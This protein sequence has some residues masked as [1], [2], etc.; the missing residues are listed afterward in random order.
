MRVSDEWATVFW[1]VFFG[2]FFFAQKCYLTRHHPR[3]YLEELV[4]KYAPFENVRSVA[5]VSCSTGRGISELKQ[6]IAELV[7][8]LGFFD[9]VRVRICCQPVALVV[10]V[11]CGSY[12]CVCNFANFMTDVMMGRIM[13][14]IS[15]YQLMWLFVLTDSKQLLLIGGAN[16]RAQAHAARAHHPICTVPRVSAA[17]RRARRQRGQRGAVSARP[18]RDSVF[19]RQGP[20]CGGACNVVFIF[21]SSLYEVEVWIM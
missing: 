2:F 18:R 4:S 7:P 20:A 6:A 14:V 10:Y 5:P 11:K 9:T 15:S 1:L 19:R 8:T 16:S 13:R 17:V 3:S 12:R 21:L